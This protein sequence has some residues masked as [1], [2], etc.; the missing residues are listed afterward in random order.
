MTSKNAQNPAVYVIDDDEDLRDVL[1]A[2]F[3]TVRIQTNTYGSVDDFLHDYKTSSPGCILLDMRLPGMSG[4]DLLNLLKKNGD[5]I[6]VIMFTGYADVP[7]AVRAMKLGATDVL[8]KGGSPQEL[9]EYVQRALA[10]DQESRRAWNDLIENGRRLENL[11][12]REREIANLVVD[13]LTTV[14]IA[15]KLSIS[16]KTVEVHRTSIMK[17]TGVHSVAQL[18]RLCLQAKPKAA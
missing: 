7:T 12:D 17:K 6:P 9:I 2:L 13:G 10:N 14:E 8:E 15:T 18:V 11:T 3:L 4:V 1:A 16:P 5:P